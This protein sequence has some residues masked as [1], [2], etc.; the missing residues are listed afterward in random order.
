MINGKRS[1]GMCRGGTTVRLFG[2]IAPDL[3]Q[4]CEA[5][6]GRKWKCG[7]ASAAMVLET[8]KGKT[9]ICKGY[10]KNANGE[11][12]A[13][14]MFDGVDLNRHLVREGWVLA[15]PRHTVKYM[16]EE[17]EAASARKGLWQG[18]SGSSFDWRNR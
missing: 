1:F 10:T 13:D 2:V 8:V 16:M 5:P 3:D 9:L 11:L 7:R 18:I 12:L 6:G 4:T 17:K 14:C 15:Y